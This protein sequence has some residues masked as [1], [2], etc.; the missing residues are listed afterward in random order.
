MAIGTG[1]ILCRILRSCRA[2]LYRRYPCLDAAFAGLPA[3]A[4]EE[5]DRVGT[6]GAQLFVSLAY[7]IRAYAESPERLVRGYLHVLLHCLYLHMVREP[8]FEERLWDV[9]CDLAVEQILE[10][11]SEKYT[12]LAWKDG[13]EGVVSVPG[14]EDRE[15]RRDAFAS[16]SR[17]EDRK[18][19]QCGFVSESRGEDRKNRQCVCV[20]ESRGEDR[21]NRQCGSVSES[22]ERNRENIQCDLVSEFGEEREKGNC[23]ESGEERLRT[24]ISVHGR[25]IQEECLRILGAEVHS[26]ERIYAML[27]QGR[28]PYTLEEIE[29]AVG[30]D[31]HRFWRDSTDTGCAGLHRKWEQIRAHAAA[32]GGRYGAQSAGTM[33]GGA[34][35]QIRVRR[36]GRRDYRSFLER[37]AVPREEVAVDTE[38]F[39]YIY[40]SYG[41]EHYGDMPLIEP[42]EYR[43]GNRLEELVIAIDTSGS[44]DTATVEQFLAETYAILSEKENFFAEMKVYLIQCDC[45]IQDVRVIRSAQEWV[46]SGGTVTVQGRGGTDFR[47]VFRYVEQLRAK[48]ELKKL[49]ALLYFT[50]GDGIYPGEAPDYETAFVCVKRT[51]GITHA[52][53]WARTFCTA[54]P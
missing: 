15:S 7:L 28:F 18:N 11:E 51:A 27:E 45:C 22:R 17:G 37:F 29:A 1:T 13:Q 24:F 49:R 19:R 38:S 41:M 9:A 21:K 43:E 10:K 14:A 26:A 32:G 5:T 8:R 47:P 54:E 53:G 12:E 34:S 44:C 39:D 16:E 46:E 35:E 33:S 30:F 36:G 31:D 23:E 2:G 3:V 25:K 6:D 48:K 52:P 40:Y 50:D 20:S 42:L 4:S